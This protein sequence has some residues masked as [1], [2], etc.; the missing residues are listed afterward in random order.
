MSCGCIGTASGSS[1]WR[2][3]EIAR[4]KRVAAI[5]TLRYFEELGAFRDSAAQDEIVGYGLAEP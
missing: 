5:R 3:D 1:P 4:Q 2:P